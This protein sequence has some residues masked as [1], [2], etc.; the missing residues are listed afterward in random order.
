MRQ[1]ILAGLLG[2]LLI[3]GCSSLPDSGPV[4]T[5]P[6]TSDQGSSQVSYFEPPGPVSGE[7]REDVVLGFLLATQANPTS[8]SVARLFLSEQVRNTWR[9]D[10]TLVYDAASVEPSSTGIRA[11]LTAVHRL[12][13]YGRWLDPSKASA[14]DLG[15]NLS[16]ENGEWRI[17]NPP[18]ELPVPLAFFRSL[19]VP[20]LLYFYDRT[21][22]VLVPSRVYLPPG[23]QFATSLVRGL[24][25]GPLGPGSAGTTTAFGRSVD[26]DLSVV[27]G[28]GGLAEVPLSA[29]IQRLSPAELARVVMQL[30]ATLGQVPGLTAFRVTVAGVPIPLIGGRSEVETDVAASLDPATA[31]GPGAGAAVLPSTCTTRPLLIPTTPGPLGAAGPALRSVAEDTKKATLAA[32]AENGRSAYQAPESGPTATGRVRT[33]ISGASDLL[34][35]VYDRF[36]DLWLVDAAKGG[37]IVHRVVDGRDKI[38]EIPGVTGRSV[39]AFT[40]TRDGSQFVAADGR[41]STPTL[42]V[43]ALVRSA[44]GAVTEALAAQRV[45]VDGADPAAVVGLD[46]DSATTVAVLTHPTNAGGKIYSAELDGSPGQQRSPGSGQIPGDLIGL[47]ASPDPA[48][49]LRVLTS[50]GSLLTLTPTGV[51]R[52]T[53]S[54]LRAAAY[55]G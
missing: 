32:V 1:P 43:S 55:V 37:A 51:W 4:H 21:G 19:F 6:D 53:V 48:L 50:D 47:L 36:G 45:V 15:F 11:R 49:P 35:P 3:A 26:L 25:A 7:S 17:T 2:A 24:L 42:L 46:Q 16:V 52:R 10:G 5:Q 54:G 31:A 23:E 18:A 28:T 20:Y 12:D 40:V 27:V 30:A 8:T 39:A 13:P 38:I 22:S 44:T 33:V 29:G 9:P 34:P 14:T 41:S